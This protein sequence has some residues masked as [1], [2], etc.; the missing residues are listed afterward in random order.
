MFEELAAQA[1][2]VRRTVTITT[3]E[4]WTITIEAA[5]VAACQPDW[6]TAADRALI[7]DRVNFQQ[8]EEA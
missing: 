7:D 4:T 2:V 3:I 1:R 6:T 5:Q 8:Q